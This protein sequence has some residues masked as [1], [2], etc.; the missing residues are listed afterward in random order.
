M[1]AG[2]KKER[3]LATVLQDAHASGRD[4]LSEAAAVMVGSAQAAS[5]HARD[6]AWALEALGEAEAA[7]TEAAA[8]RL[9]APTA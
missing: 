2:S 4:A 5:I 8:S 6:A 7:L 9:L 3:A 1:S